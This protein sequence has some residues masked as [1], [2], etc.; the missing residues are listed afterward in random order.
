MAHKPPIPKGSPPD[1]SSLL[2]EPSQAGQGLPGSFMNVD[3]LEGLE[4]S[5]LRKECRGLEKSLKIASS[6]RKGLSGCVRPRWILAIVR[7]RC[8]SDHQRTHN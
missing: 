6:G 7:E 5:D 8:G 4:E 3:S 1:T 2:P